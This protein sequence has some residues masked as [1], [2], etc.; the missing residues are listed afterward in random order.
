MLDTWLK[1]IDDNWLVGTIFLDFQKAFDIVD[2]STLVKKLGLYGLRE[3]SVKWFSFYLSNHKQKESLNGWVS[4]FNEITAGVPQGSILG[5]LLFI[6][7]INDMF[8]HDSSVD[9]KNSLYADDSFFYTVG[10]TVAE[11]ETNLNQ[12]LKKVTNWCTRN[13]MFINKTK[14]KSMLLCTRQKIMNLDSTLKIKIDN[15]FLRII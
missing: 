4:D 12:D 3:N 11:I 6:I 15:E 1:A 9:N 14:T 7:F 10:N 8:M 13:R 2:H 5:P